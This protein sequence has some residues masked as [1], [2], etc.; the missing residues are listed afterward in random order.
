M[1]LLDQQL[2]EELEKRGL[3]D[4]TKQESL[5]EEIAS[6]QEKLATETDEKEKQSLQE[7]LVTKQKELEKQKILDE[8][9]AKKKETEKKAAMDTY[10][11]EVEIF[12]FQKGVQIAMVWL[13]AGMGIVAAWAQSIAQ[14]GPVAGAVMAG[15]LTAAML[16]VAGVQTAMI[17][18]KQPPSPPRL[19]KGAIVTKATIAEI[20]EGED[21]EAVIPLN[22]QSFSRIA[23]G[24][25]NEF[26]KR[27]KLPTAGST[28]N[29]NTESQDNSKR[30]NVY[31]NIIVKP[32][33]YENFKDQL[34]NEIEK[35]Q[36]R[37]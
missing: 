4:K 5:E 9:E 23:Q 17:A 31:G 36:G 10:N 7:E 28:Y 29:S 22:E 13:Q 30:I 18:S 25:S 3:A 19:A 34:I 20:G 8:Y 11:K 2:N 15:I 16:A 6:I 26:E 33:N 14:L 21:P 1:D 35:D 27:E 24:I 32:Y 37:S 12:N